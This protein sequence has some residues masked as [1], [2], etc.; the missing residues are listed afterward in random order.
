[1]L[2]GQTISTWLARK[3]APD[4]DSAPAAYVSICPQEGRRSYPQRAKVS[5]AD[6]P[7]D[8][9]VQDVLAAIADIDESRRNEDAPLVRVRLHVYGPKGMDSLGEMVFVVG[10]DNQDAGGPD[11]S[12]EGELIAAL[13]EMRMLAADA[14][15]G[16]SRASSSGYTLALE[17]LKENARLQHELADHKAALQLAEQGE[18][19]GM[20]EGAL[21]A[22]LPVVA[23]R[24][25]A[26]QDTPAPSPPPALP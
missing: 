16:L 5:A 21:Q 13:R 8:Q 25:M 4:P 19:G 11:G 20:L 17:A 26:S 23:A 9:V 15:A 18:K 1:M 10:A 24:M 14:V 12:R 7:A 6:R 22:V 2:N 3:L